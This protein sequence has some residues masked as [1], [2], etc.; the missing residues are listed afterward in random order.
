MCVL[1]SPSYGALLWHPKLTLIE[2]ML[3][4][5]TP[6]TEA[7]LSQQQTDCE[8]SSK[9]VGHQE[10]IML[11]KPRDKHFKMKGVDIKLGGLVNSE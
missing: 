1:L 6:H 2:P 9:K 3:L 4:T 11:L 7:F 5:A 10:R 8:E